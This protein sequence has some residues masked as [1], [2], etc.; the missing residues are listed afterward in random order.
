MVPSSLPATSGVGFKPEHLS[1]I[2]ADGG[3]PG[4]FEVHAE[5]ATNGELLRA[6]RVVEPWRDLLNDFAAVVL[7]RRD[8]REQSAQTK[9]SGF[10]LSDSA[11]FL[12]Q[13]EYKL[14]LI[15]P[16]AAAYGAAFAE[17]FFPILL[18]VGFATRFSAFALLAMTAVIE[19]FVYPDAWP[20][21]GVWA[22]CF[23][24]VIARGPGAISLD[25]LIASRRR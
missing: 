10:G 9:V 12:F 25:H 13:E 7:H 8:A 6:P 11:V 19:I 1:A 20:T 21:H 2:R 3:F 15:N 24:L 18:V 4:F 22:A 16:T 23:L 14:P 5:T 17:H